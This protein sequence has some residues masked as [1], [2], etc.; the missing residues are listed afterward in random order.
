MAV[1]VG[2]FSPL[3]IAAQGETKMLIDLLAIGVNAEAFFTSANS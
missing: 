2:A 3:F 1:I